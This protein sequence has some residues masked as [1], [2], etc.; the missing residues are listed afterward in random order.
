MKNVVWTDGDGYKHVSRLRDRD[1]DHMA[2]EG[3]PLD[4]PDLS[5]L[6]WQEIQR[7]LHNLLVDKELFTW[8]DV[9]RSQNGV[10]SSILSVMKRPIVA[11]YRNRNGD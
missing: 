10:S 8:K 3:I 4:P 7:E 1:P 2:P 11:L 9:Q 6:D 5:Q